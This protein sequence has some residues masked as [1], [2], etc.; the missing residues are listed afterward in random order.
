M[1]SQMRMHYFYLFPV[2]LVI[3]N[4][5]IPFFWTKII[6]IQLLISRQV[7]QKFYIPL[8]SVVVVYSKQK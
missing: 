1:V 5:G 4:L 7:I 3:P 2:Q 6:V 8:N